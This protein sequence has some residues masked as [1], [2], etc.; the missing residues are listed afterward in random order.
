MEPSVTMVAAIMYPTALEIPTIKTCQQPSATLEWFES[1]LNPK[2]RVDSLHAVIS[3]RWRIDGGEADGTRYF[4]IPSFALRK[5]PLRIDTYIPG[6]ES[7]PG[8]LQNLLQPHSTIYTPSSRIN[9]HNV[10]LYILRA[11]ELW[12]DQ[13]PNLETIYRSM[14]FGSRIIIDGISSDMRR[15]KLYF[16]PNYEIESQWLSVQALQRKFD[17]PSSS[18]PP[19]IDYQKLQLIEQ[20]HECISLVQLGEQHGSNVFVFKSVLRDIEYFYHELKQLLQ[21]SPHPN[22]V[23][24]PLYIVTKSCLFGG[25]IGVCGFVLQYYTGGTLQ[26]ALSNLPGDEDIRLKSQF[27]WARQLTSALQHIH[28]SPT[29]YYSNLKLINVV[30]NESGTYEESNA[31]LIDFEQRSG[32]FSWSAP[33]IYYIHYLEHIATFSKSSSARLKYSNLLKSYIPS[34]R[35]LNSNTRYDNP[36]HGFSFPWLALTREEHESTQVF[37]L[38]KL[39]WCIF[40]GAWGMSSAVTIE[41]FREQPCDILFPNFLRTPMRLRACIRNC[42]TG[43]PEWRGRWPGVVRR[44]NKLY[45]FQGQWD[46]VEATKV[47]EETQDSAK[48]WWRQEIQDAERFL[49]IRRR[50]KQG[51]EMEQSC[52][53]VV[54]FMKQRPTLIQVSTA[55]ESLLCE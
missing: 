33:E 29:M 2:N 8:V 24:K 32:F 54:E 36:Q 30:M 31:V 11:L 49:D 4:A 20:P 44:G 18:W 38:G 26:A 13:Q 42:T 46:G 5:P 7:F 6:S 25:K 40:E 41:T 47:T 22:I 23:S 39:L 27:R 43:A 45:P 16:M 28:E 51:E 48:R 37:M 52:K 12:S 35:P 50:M 15:L 14:P 34:W 1:T 3:P 55:L 53:K 17:L 10:S 21:L 19:I 9:T